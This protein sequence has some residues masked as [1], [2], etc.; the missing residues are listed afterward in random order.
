MGNITRTFIAALCLVGAGFSAACTG[1]VAAENHSPATNADLYPARITG[2]KTLETGKIEIRL[3]YEKAGDF[4]ASDAPTGNFRLRE[5]GIV[6]D[7]LKIENVSP[8]EIPSRTV[9]LADLSRSLTRKQFANFKR[10]ALAFA[11]RLK[12][13]D[14]AA[15]ITFHRR[16]HRD[17]NFTS[18]RELLKKRIR[19]L[20]QTGSRTMLYDALIEAHKMLADAPARKAIVL[21]TDGKENA[22]RVTMSDLIELYSANPVPL[23]VAGKHRS[24]A[25]KRLIRLARVSGG[26]AFRAD[27][28]RDLAKVFHYLTRLRQKEFLLTYKTAQ[29]S[30]ATIDIE[31]D[32]GREG[33]NLVRSYTIPTASWQAPQPVETEKPAEKLFSPGLITSLRTHMPEI[34]LSL[35]VL[36][37]VAV[38]VMLFFRKQEITVK[39]EN[40]M[41]QAFVAPGDLLPLSDKKAETEKAKLPLDYHHGWLVEKEGPHT[42]RKYRIN[43]HTVTV[44]FSDDNS[45]V[46]D[47]N[48]ASPRHA[49]I[50]R[51][52][53][54]FVLYDLMSE[55]GTLLNGKKLLRPKELNDFDEI[56]VGRT[57][58]IFRKSSASFEKSTQAAAD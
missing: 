11:D 8:R 44:G 29:K 26:D 6:Q 27:D 1:Q 7:S 2:V 53:R 22:S 54:K 45:I 48:T 30:G 33:R 17:L 43:W 24:Y 41:P 25:L 23:F 42:G 32:T 34:L 46:I 39:V 13:G 5:N 51:E 52:G 36:L 4:D 3:V 55:T 19:A 10:A 37:L 38:I 15:L 20:R 9:I 58:L 18:D 35:I 31:I 57:K 12:P 47:D 21:Y 14:T 16:V 56:G 40:Q 28:G 49:K 50:E